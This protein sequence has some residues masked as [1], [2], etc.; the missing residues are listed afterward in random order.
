MD[1]SLLVLLYIGNVQIQSSG[2]LG[3]MSDGMSGGMSDD[4]PGVVP[5]GMLGE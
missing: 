2:M 4:M 3:G 1:F 5:G